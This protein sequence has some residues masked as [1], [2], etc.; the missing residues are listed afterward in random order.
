[1]LTEQHDT[2]FIREYRP[3]LGTSKT[4]DRGTRF[5]YQVGDSMQGGRGGSVRTLQRA[6]TAVRT[7]GQRQAEGR[8][9]YTGR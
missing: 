8:D 3:P 7:L 2:G 9:R 5:M 1:M 6:R 4:S